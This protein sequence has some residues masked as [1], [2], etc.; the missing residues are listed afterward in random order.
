MRVFVD[1]H[2]SIASLTD[3]PGRGE[4]ATAFLNEP[5]EFVTS[6]LNLMELRTV[7]AKKKEIEQERV[8]AIIQ[9]IRD[10]IAIYQPDGE[11]I[12]AAY[13][14]QRSTLLYQLDCVYLSMAEFAEAT[15]VTFDNELIDDGAVP[16]DDVT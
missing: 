15:P 11:D 3:E 12:L 10:T 13:E 6:I 5:H 14:R 1:T 7:L 8:E 2:V 4:E 9:D 16:S